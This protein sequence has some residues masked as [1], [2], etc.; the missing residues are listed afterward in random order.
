MNTVKHTFIMSSRVIRYSTRSIDTVITVIVMPI[1]ILL[2]FVYILGG[3]METGTTSYVNYI[4]P[5]VLLY[6][7]TSGV[8][9]SSLRVNNDLNKGIFE[10]FH[11]MPIAKSSILAG[12]VIASII[13]NIVSLV[14][15]F[16]VAFLIGFRS[17]AN[18][19]EWLLAITL[20][21][22]SVLAM[23]W[24]ALTFGLL[25][26][27]FE[28]AGVFAY[29][30]MALLFVSSSFAPVETMPRALEIFA[31]YQPMTPIIEGIRSLLLGNPNWQ[32]ITIAIIWCVGI[33]ILFYGLSM[34]T[35]KRRLK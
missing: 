14:V 10:R 21:L 19:H 26:K 2:A 9:Y 16:I 28:G 13:S 8:A 23:T 4:V 17:P 31:T 27:T 3:A 33:S 22:L 15:I 11:S 25:A 30:L 5:G 7:I 1:M 34:L 6:C 29:I 20:L 35:Y 32:S 24:M 12:H 18:I